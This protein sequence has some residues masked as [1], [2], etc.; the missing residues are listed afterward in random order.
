MSPTKE[1]VR[2]ALDLA[3]TAAEAVRQAGP[4]G[5]PSGHLYAALMGKVTLDGYQSMIGMLKRA[6]LI[7]ESAHL[8]TWIGPQLKKGEVLECEMTRKP[9]GSP[10][11]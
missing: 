1:Q 7:K 10:S 11:I 2:A 5:L 4:M 8:L 3:V 9:S 6:G